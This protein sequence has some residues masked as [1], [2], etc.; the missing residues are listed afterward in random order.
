MIIKNTVITATNR[1]MKNVL[2]HLLDKPHENEQIGVVSGSRQHVAMAFETAKQFGRK[3]GVAHFI[4]SSKE[5]LTPAQMKDAMGAVAAEFGFNSNDIRLTVRHQ[6]K[7]HDVGDNKAW[8]QHFHMLVRTTNPETGRVL[9]LSNSYA[10]LEKTCRVFEA[11]HDLKIVKG[12]HDKAVLHAVDDP[13][14]RAKLVAAGI[15]QGR[16]PKAAFTSTEKEMGKR[17]GTDLSDV[18]NAMRAAWKST[19]NWQDFKASVEGHGWTIA[20]G[21]RKPDVLV[22]ND[23]NGRYIGAVGRLLGVNKAA[24]E[25]VVAGEPIPHKGR[26][27]DAV[28]RP[29]PAIVDTEAKPSKTPE[30]P[31][32][33]PA[34]SP[35]I[36]SKST[37]PDAGT[38]RVQ[39]TIHVDLKGKSEQERNAEIS[40][41]KAEAEKVEIANKSLKESKQFYDDMLEMFSIKTGKGKMNTITLTDSFR[42]VCAG[43]IENFERIRDEPLPT[44]EMESYDVMTSK[45]KFEFANKK[46]LEGIRKR[47]SEI[48]ALEQ[49]IKDLKSNDHW[50]NRNGTKADSKEAQNEEK[51]A[52]LQALCVWFARKLLSK[53]NVVDDPGPWRSHTPREWNEMIVSDREMRLAE[54]IDQVADMKATG[55]KKLTQEAVELL[56]ESL[57]KWKNRPEVHDATKQIVAIKSLLDADE[58]AERVAELPDADKEKLIAD[59]AGHDPCGAVKTLAAGEIHAADIREQ[60]HQK[61]EEIRKREQEQAEIRERE[62]KEKKEKKGQ[63]KNDNQ[64]GKKGSEIKIA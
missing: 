35:Q 1:S 21:T 28:A 61:L 60:E 64:K 12:K 32:A 58:F 39:S 9:D 18:R 26:K 30:K 45:E 16:R 24:L 14:I 33:K 46:V 4:F 53:F 34:K 5:A 11:K 43:E 29:E 42:M 8:D 59:I 37:V 31:D 19:E 23:E 25:R 44:E 15:G 41:E 47:K 38:G 54:V 52:V 55:Y 6:K 50:W 7:R 48:R 22:L 10:R 27:P 17:D 56:D 49:E 20:P 40:T 2:R 63:A 62:Q 57:E 13:E 3:N 36:R 51:K